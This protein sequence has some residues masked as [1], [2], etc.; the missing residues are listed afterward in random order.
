MDFKDR[1]PKYPGR[2]KLTP[3]SGQANVYDMTLQDDA[4]VVGTP[5]NAA[6]LD[7]FK[8]EIIDYV[9]DNPGQQGEKGEQGNPGEVIDKKTLLVGSNEIN[10]AGWYKLGSVEFSNQ[11]YMDY[12]AKI[13][14][15][16]T[17]E[18]I[19]GV[20]MPSGLIGINMRY[21]GDG[22][23]NVFIK[24]EDL[25]GINPD[26][27]CYTLSGQ[28]FTLYGY[29]PD[30][31]DFYRV[32]IL[33]ESNRDGYTTL[34]KPVVAYG[35]VSQTRARTTVPVSAKYPERDYTRFYSWVHNGECKEDSVT[36][37]TKS[38][39][40]LNNVRGAIVI[41]ISNVTDGGALEKYDNFATGN[42]KYGVFV[43]NNTVYVAIDVGTFKY[44]F[45]CLIYGE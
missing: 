25:R 15:T 36:V 33:A 18:R 39:H 30:Q 20:I 13:L 35:G 28:V 42:V 12:H 23:E 40:G 44:G 4:S 19:N 24:W 43:Q 1:S 6:T 38:M 10:R 32:D 37:C 9:N 29:I 41:P 26:Y 27:I 34:F 11:I 21:G 7:A 5:L 16:K 2:V 14:I 17:F 8:Q 22:W 31:C 45:Y 3:V